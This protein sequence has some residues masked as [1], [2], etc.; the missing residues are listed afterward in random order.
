MTTE[1]HDLRDVWGPGAG[2]RS[3]IA[4]CSC[5]WQSAPQ[6]SRVKAEDE[7]VAHR[8]AEI[9]DDDPRSV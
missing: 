6:D 4:R 1:M 2:G 5:G 9:P 7:H 8:L 3:Y